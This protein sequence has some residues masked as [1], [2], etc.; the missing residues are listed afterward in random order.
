MRAGL[1][2]IGASLLTL[3]ALA[4]C[5][6]PGRPQVPPAVA[7]VD[8]VILLTRV[9]PLR[10]IGEGESPNAIALEVFFEKAGQPGGVPV[11]GSLEVLIFEGRVPPEELLTRRP[12]HVET[13]TNAMLRERPDSTLREGISPRL[14]VSYRGA[15][16]W[17][18]KAPAA[19]LLTVAARYIPP[20]GSPVISAPITFPRVP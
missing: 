10:T 11:S 8:E 19:A 3:G 9:N 14:G 6:E 15:V 16:P 12:F 5:V 7:Q 13:Y 20:R 1:H 4:G 2:I 17:G 18:E